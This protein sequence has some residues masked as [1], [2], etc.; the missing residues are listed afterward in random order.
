M[1]L[2]E[3]ATMFKDLVMANSTTTVTAKMILALPVP[4]LAI[5]RVSVFLLKRRKTKKNSLLGNE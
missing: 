2:C 3:E 4:I 1:V 5:L